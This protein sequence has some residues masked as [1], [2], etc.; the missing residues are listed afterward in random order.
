MGSSEKKDRDG[1]FP[2]AEFEYE[3][4]PPYHWNASVPL[5]SK[6]KMFRVFPSGVKNGI[7]ES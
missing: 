4:N 1:Q 2:N 5:I 7:M 3:N 6:G